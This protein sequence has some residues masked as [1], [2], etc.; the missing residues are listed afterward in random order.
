MRELTADLFISLDGFASGVDQAPYFGYF[1]P[2]LGKWVRE[3]L[4][5][6]QI[7]VM[8]GVTYQALARFSASASDEVSARM[9]ELPKLVFSNTLQEPLIWK[10]TRRV[11]GIARDEITALK[12]QDGD[13]LRSIGSIS[14]VRSMF[15]A[16]LVDRL[17][18]MVFPVILGTSG[19]EPIYADFPQ[20][21]L[22]LIQTRVLDSAVILLEYRPALR[23]HRLGEYSARALVL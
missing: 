2:D 17:R 10:N 13:P 23:A 7:I 21:A 11:R 22:E 9:R 19:R 12:Q 18:L 6:P 14:L 16:R 3:H 20:A 4:D 8:G 15:K 5:Q 1:G